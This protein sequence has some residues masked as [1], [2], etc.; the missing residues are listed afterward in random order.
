MNDEIRGVSESKPCAK[1]SVGSQHTATF[2]A[3]LFLLSALFLISACQS[4]T[5]AEEE[6]LLFQLL[7]DDVMAAEDAL[8]EIESLGD[9]NFSA[10]LI[11]LYWAGR[12]GINDWS[13]DAET[14]AALESITN[15]SFGGRLG[16][17]EDLV[18][19]HRSRAAGRL[20]RLESRAF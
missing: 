20:S 8:A 18:R 16:R 10:P 3:F 4:L 2:F 12:I 15:Q 7:A 17:L 5:P 6:A 19:R 14:I 1:Q 13:G 11:E 9:R